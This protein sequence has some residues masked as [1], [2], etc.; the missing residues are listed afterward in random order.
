MRLPGAVRGALLDAMRRVEV[1]AVR[2]IPRP[3]D[4]V[5][6]R[7]LGVVEDAVRGRATPEERA[8]FR[9]IEALRRTLLASNRRVALP[10][11]GPG[12]S[13]VSDREG[14]S[15]YH[16]TPTVA[17]QCAGSKSPFGARVLF[18]L[19]REFR[20][21]RCLE[22]GTNLGISAA[23]QEAALRLNGTGALA[24]IEGAPDLA[25]LAREHLAQLGLDAEVLEGR[26]GDVLPGVLARSAPLDYVFIDGHHDGPATVA[27]F[28]QI[29]PSLARGA[30]VVFDDVRW[31]SAMEGAWET[32]RADPR[33]RV[34]VG[35]GAMGIAW[36]DGTDGP[37]AR[38]D[39]PLH[40]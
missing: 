24:T 32:V 23:Y 37:R 19:L 26:F 38:A 5:L 15:G 13:S 10:D 12:H 21:A 6:Q 27:Y 39:V 2:R 22:L 33:V 31:S 40:I 11:Y 25:R 34:S 7:I 16:A 36:V 14:W 18:R 1:R 30:L 29:H 8:W 17:E 9:R 3:R 4:P 28:D 20:P 35:L